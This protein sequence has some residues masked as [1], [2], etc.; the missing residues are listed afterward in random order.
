V[1]KNTGCEPG[2]DPIGMV[3]GWDGTVDEAYCTEV[4]GHP[5]ELRCA[6]ASTGGRCAGKLPADAPGV[7]EQSGEPVPE[8]PANLAE[9]C[10][11]KSEECMHACAQQ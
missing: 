7:P 9:L 4:E 2:N 10:S 1:A 3:C 11:T 8:P 5:D 6:R